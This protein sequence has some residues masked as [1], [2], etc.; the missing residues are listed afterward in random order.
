VRRSL[1]YGVQ[2]AARKTAHRFAESGY[3]SGYVFEIDCIFVNNP[4]ILGFF[5]FQY[6]SCYKNGENRFT[7]QLK[8][9]GKTATLRVSEAVE[10][11]AF[12]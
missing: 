9:A 10:N 2:P 5:M 1:F 6:A 11:A 3:K 4:S 8:P 12:D 7:R